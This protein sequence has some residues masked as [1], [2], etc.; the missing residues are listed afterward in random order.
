MRTTDDRAG[1]TTAGVEGYLTSKLSAPGYA[2]DA[3]LARGVQRA[4]DAGMPSIAVSPMVG[5]L[6]AIM[7]KSMKA[8]RVLEIGT[9]GG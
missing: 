2:G 4:R 7:A 3:A 9:L 8:T 6:L 5:Q 1:Q